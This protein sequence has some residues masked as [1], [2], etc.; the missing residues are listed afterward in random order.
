MG[1]FK[2]KQAPPPRPKDYRP[3]VQEYIE[4]I[5]NQLELPEANALAFLV[6]VELAG[7]DIHSRYTPDDLLQTLVFT[8]DKSGYNTD[9]NRPNPYINPYQNKPQTGH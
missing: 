8:Q 5:I 6:A 4:R 1:Y 9:G 7:G 2:D 3:T